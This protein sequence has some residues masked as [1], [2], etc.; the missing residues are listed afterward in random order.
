[1]CSTLSVTSLHITTCST[2]GVTTVWLSTVP[3]TVSQ[4]SV[5]ST[6]PLIV[7]QQSVLS[8]VPLTMS[9]QFD[10]QLFHWQCHNSL[11]VNCSTDNVTT[12]CLVNCS[13]DSVTTVCLVNCSTDSVTTVWLSNVPLMASQPSDCQLFQWWRHKSALSTVPLTM[14][15]QSAFSTVPLAVSQQPVLSTVPLTVSQQSVL[16]TVPLTMSQQSVLS[17]VPLTVSQQSVLSTVPL[18]V[19]QP[20]D[21]QMFHWWRHNPLTVNCSNDGVTSLLC[22]L[23]HWQCHNSLPSQLFHWQCHNSLSCPL[24]HWQ[25]HNSLSCQLFHWQCHNSLSCQLFHWQCHNSLTVSCSTDGVTTVWLSTVPLTVSQQ[26]DCQLFHWRRHNCLSC[27][28]FLRQT[29]D[30][31]FHKPR[32]MSCI[33]CSKGG[34]NPQLTALPPSFLATGSC[35]RKTEGGRKKG[36]KSS[37]GKRTSSQAQDFAAALRAPPPLTCPLWWKMSEFRGS[38]SSALAKHSMASLFKS[39]WISKLP[40]LIKA[41]AATCR[42]QQKEPVQVSIIT[43]PSVQQSP[44][45]SKALCSAKPSVQQSKGGTVEEWSAPLAWEQAASGL[46]LGWSTDPPSTDISPPWPYLPPPFWLAHTHTH[47]HT[48][49]TPPMCTH[50]HT[51][52]H[53]HTY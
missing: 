31:C 4:Q 23:F 14:S 41:L 44:L 28:L 40:F 3:L 47:T 22:Q 15:Q 48:N 29:A 8:T 35:E 1:M 21:C 51:H 5:L 53:T 26:S 30:S 38:S 12:V 13:T 43:T 18:T 33:L 36:R 10:C 52:T 24:F 19:S 27:Q 2:D 7:S 17:T 9:Q 25:C 50:T 6:V 16:S 42:T 11:T 20:S 46:N 45:F 37:K 39:F 34:S 32:G 49:N